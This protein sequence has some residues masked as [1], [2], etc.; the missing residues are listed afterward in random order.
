MTDSDVS[1]ARKRLARELKILVAVQVIAFCIAGLGVCLFGSDIVPNHP[2]WDT[3]HSLCGVLG[4]CGIVVFVVAAF[5]G[6]VKPAI[7]NFLPCRVQLYA[8]GTW[9][10]L[11]I[12]V[13]LQFFY[14][15]F[16]PFEEPILTLIPI[17]VFPFYS[18]I[19][20]FFIARWL[21]KETKN[22]TMTMNQV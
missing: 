19:S 10:I 14:T 5:W 22:G 18:I 3:A 13:I 17:Y 16:Q 6:S 1:L 9:G 20:Q 11:S 7:A 21:A 4:L 8:S 12:F 15:T 2:D